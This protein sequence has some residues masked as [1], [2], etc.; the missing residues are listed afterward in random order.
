[1]PVCCCI[2]STW[3]SVLKIK[4]NF[5]KFAGQTPIMLAEDDDEMVALLKNHLYDVQNTGPTK[6]PWK[7]RGAWEIY[8]KFSVETSFLNCKTKL[9][10][11][12]PNF[13]DSHENGYN[14]FDGLP[15][16]IDCKIAIEASVKSE[17]TEPTSNMPENLRKSSPQSK[18][19]A[20][21][22]D[23]TPPDDNDSDL[24]EIEESEA[25]LVPLYHLR[26][27]GMHKWVLLSDLCYVLKVKSKDSLLKQ[28]NGVCT[29]QANE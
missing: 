7:F 15:T 4:F 28:V 9:K 19:A 17:K 13:S 18:A 23:A 26:D 2:F 5:T 3:I 16:E 27:E 22:A 12:I 21:K 11:S 24:F 8:G 25:P 1:M 14:I 10:K 6:M 20:S 29:A